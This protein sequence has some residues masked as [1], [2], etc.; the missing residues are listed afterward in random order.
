MVTRVLRSSLVIPVL[1]LLFCPEIYAQGRHERREQ[2][3]KDSENQ[4]AVADELRKAKEVVVGVPYDRSWETVVQVLKDKGLPIDKANK[5]IGQIKTE[6]QIVDPKK[7][8]QRG[9]RYLIDFRRVSE[10]ETGLKVAALEQI[11]TYRLQA[12]PWEE[13]KYNAEASVALTEAIQQATAS[14]K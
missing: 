7:P 8:T 13:P 12:E 10:S 1:V 3:L 11:R 2:R 5:D 6:F 4:N 9:M 14:K